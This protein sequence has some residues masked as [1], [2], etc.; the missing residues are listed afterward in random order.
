[1]KTTYYFLVIFWIGESLC[2]G[3][4][5][6]RIVAP[7]AQVVKLA[8]GFKFTEGP[9]SDK[10]GN[11][12][13]TDIPNN[14]IH[15]WS[16]QG[17]LSTFREDSGGAN[18]LFFDRQ[19]DLVACEGTARRLVSIGPKDKLTVLAERYQNKRFNSLNDLWI[20]PKGGIYF[21]DPRYGSQEGM[22]QDG[23]HVYYLLP[24]RK[25]VIRVIDDM[26]QPN[27]I[28]GNP[29]GE[30]LYV[31]DQGD[32]KTFVYHT[33]EDGILSDKKL[34]A[35]EGSDGMTIDDEGNIY[36]TTNVVAVYDPNGRKI[37]EIEVP[38]QPS[39]VCFGGEDNQTL[40][41]TA[42]TSL[43]SIRTTVR[44]VKGKKT[45]EQ[46]KFEEDII[47]TNTGDL[48]ITCI[49]H[50]TLMFT[51]QGKTIHIDPWSDQADYSKMSQADVILITHDHSDHFDPK[52]IKSL[53]KNTTILIAPEKCA[54][55]MAHTVIMRNGDVKTFDALKVEAVPAYNLLHKRPDGVPFHPKSDG[56]GYVLTLGDKRVYV[57]GDTENIPAMQSLKLID[58]AFLPMNLPYTMTPVMVAEAA[59]AFR[60]A[61][62]YPYHYGQTD[63]NQLVELLK[64]S[65]DIEVRIRS[66]R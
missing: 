52:A 32:G 1:M 14:R 61:I 50:G 35:L 36:L 45:V 40:F 26:V 56:N 46:P 27:G 63:P 65:T 30:L 54:S 53:R 7:G 2:F 18:G 38:E 59:K 62:L 8:D 64:D 33:K 57:A 5:G 3:T 31:T 13:F 12:F 47:K 49:G 39:N 17:K 34:F 42:R 60:P 41:I 15:Q 22:E 16:L 43:Y 51:F 37:E 19:G 24:D 10:S 21:T 25:K 28:I 55:K 44:G 6:H 4:Q 11:L 9:A 20:D 66:L 48:K 58:V 29:E 23:E